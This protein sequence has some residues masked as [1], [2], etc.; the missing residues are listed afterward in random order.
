MMDSRN[1][2]DPLLKPAFA[3]FFLSDGKP[4]SR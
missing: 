2:F 4:E 1:I 3:G